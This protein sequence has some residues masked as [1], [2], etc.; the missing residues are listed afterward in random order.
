MQSKSFTLSSA[1]PDNSVDV[2]LALSSVAGVGARQWHQ[3]CARFNTTFARLANGPTENMDET[4]AHKLTQALSRQQLSKV[5]ASL[6]WAAA[7]PSHHLIPYTSDLYPPLLRH[8]SDAPLILFVKGNTQRIAEVQLAM[9]GSRN[10]TRPGLNTTWRLAN[11]LAQAGLTITSG[12]ATGVDGYAHKGALQ[13][14]G[15]T[16]AVTGTGPDI[17][18]PRRHQQLEQD[19]INSGGAVVSEFWPGTGARAGHFPRRNR[20][21][22]AM[23]LATLVVEAKIRSGTLITANLAADM[24]RDVFVVP[25]SIDNPLTQGCHHLIQQ[26]AALITCAQDVL[27]ELP[28]QIRRSHVDAA[29]QSEKS[30]GE[31]LATDKLLASVDYDVTNVDIITERSKLPVSDVLASLLHYELRGLVAAVPGGYIKLRGK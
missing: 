15:K 25:G 9:V 13:A 20:L 8:L 19:I 5:E 6:N 16:V 29:G 30:N 2:C 18:Y 1:C 26:G 17:I 3:L 31:N 24:G 4:T 7:N 21:I 22:A 10:A 12:L 27:N 28:V 14:E 11:E 23:T